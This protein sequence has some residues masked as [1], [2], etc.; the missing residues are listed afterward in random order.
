MGDKAR[1]TM[2]QTSGIAASL[3]MSVAKTVSESTATVPPPLKRL[4][5]LTPAA[6]AASRWTNSSIF[7][8]EIT[9]LRTFVIGLPR[10]G[11][12]ETSAAMLTPGYHGNYD[13]NI[14]GSEWQR[15]RRCP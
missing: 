10:N 6:F 9:T 3:E 5:T 2:S 8:R 1:S 7:L 12:S 13:M 4:M 14:H 15:T 11:R